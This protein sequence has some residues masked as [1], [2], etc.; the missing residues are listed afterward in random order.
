MIA[1]RP[2]TVYGGG[3]SLDKAAKTYAAAEAAGKFVRKRTGVTPP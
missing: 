3:E 2:L 1:P